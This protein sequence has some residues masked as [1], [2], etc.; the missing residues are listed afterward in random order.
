MEL[1]GVDENGNAV[2]TTTHLTDFAMLTDVVAEPDAFFAAATELDINLPVVMSGEELLSVLA[3][4][5]PGA[6]SAIALTGT[7]MV[8]LFLLA[9]RYDDRHAYTAF[10]PKWF[11]F[12]SCFGGSKLFRSVGAQLILLGTTNHFLMI[13]FVLPSIPTTRTQ[14]LMTVYQVVLTELI[15]LMMFYGTSNTNPLVSLWAQIIQGGT[16]VIVK[17]ISVTL[18]NWALLPRK[19]TAP[20]EKDLKQLRVFHGTEKPKKKGLFQRGPKSSS[21]V[22]R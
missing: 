4:I 5:S 8:M 13:F 2:C 6:W 9:Q 15:V 21:N 17:V 16:T 19:T 10:Y 14:R 22:K 12:L 11:E 20:T 7:V 1:T 3:N 18:C